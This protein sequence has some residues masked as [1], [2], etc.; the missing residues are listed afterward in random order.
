MAEPRPAQ[1]VTGALSLTAGLCLYVYGGGGVWGVHIW[2]VCVYIYMFM[3]C[4]CVLGCIYLIYIYGF[5]AYLYLMYLWVYTYIY[6]VY[7][8][9]CIC[10][11]QLLLTVPSAPSPFTA[12][13]PAARLLPGYFEATCL[14]PVQP[15]PLPPP[16]Q[17]RVP[18]VP[19][20]P[21][22]GWESRGPLP[23][24]WQP[25]GAGGWPQLLV[26]VT[27]VAAAG[28]ASC[29]LLWGLLLGLGRGVQA[30]WMHQDE[31]LSTGKFILLVVPREPLREGGWRAEHPRV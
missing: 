18:L 14:S 4:I 11:V 28:L 3:G 29:S 31:L 22:R 25:P 26:A 30:L 9:R 8:L 1:L 27:E 12:S 10:R 7:N 15:R 24:H 13:P 23:S 6:G 21:P 5:M 19:S 17:P 16:S 2:G 20:K